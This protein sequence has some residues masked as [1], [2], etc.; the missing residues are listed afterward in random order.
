MGQDCTAGG[1]SMRRR[2]G[3][4]RAVGR[5]LCVVPPMTAMCLW[6]WCVRTKPVMHDVMEL[7]AL[8]VRVSLDGS[9]IVIKRA[10]ATT[11]D[12]LRDDELIVAPAGVWSSATRLRKCEGLVELNARVR[13][14]LSPGR[15]GFDYFTMKGVQ[16]LSISMW[17]LALVFSP[18][19]L[20]QSFAL[21]HSAKAY[22]RRR[23]NRC[24]HCGYQLHGLVT[25]RCPECGTSI[26]PREANATR[27]RSR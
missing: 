1:Q 18:L 20:P 24:L 14:Q 13:M 3:R 2:Y 6:V 4:V 8:R 7:P 16:I 23:G 17:L 12:Q 9:L 10:N 15:E 5:A 21:A 22:W 27:D 11:G 26:V 25:S 19:L